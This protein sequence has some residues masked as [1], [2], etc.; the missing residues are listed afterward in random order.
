MDMAVIK[1]I[2][3]LRKMTVGGPCQSS[4]RAFPQ[5]FP[6]LSGSPAHLAPLTRHL[7]SPGTWHLG[8]AR[9]PRFLASNFPILWPA[10]IRASTPVG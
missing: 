8:C 9:T 6:P 10:R 7:R 3:A 4:Q 5:W 1:E 2:E